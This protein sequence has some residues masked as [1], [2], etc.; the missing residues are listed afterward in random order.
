MLFD[1]QVFL[2]GDAK[3]M[4]PGVHAALVQ[5]VQEHGGQSDGQAYWAQAEENGRYHKDVY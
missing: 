1:S 3:G 2:C 5:V 4:A